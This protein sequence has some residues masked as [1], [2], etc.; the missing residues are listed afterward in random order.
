VELLS[1]EHVG[2]VVAT[3][4]AAAVAVPAARRWP[5]AVSRGLAVVIGVTY[6][7]EHAHFIARGTWSL[8]FNLP[9]H[10]TDVVTI[11]SVLALWTARPLLVELTWFWALTASLQAVL[12]PD[13]GA[14]FPELVY[15]TFFITHSGAVVAAVV[16]VIG[17]GIHPRPGAVGR[18]FVATL[19]VAA[20]AG[21][22]NLLTGGNYMWLREKPD[23][24]SLL[25]VMGP[26]PWY[27]L[28][29]AVVALVL[30]TLLAA[31][32]RRR[33][34][35][36]MMPPERVEKLRAW[37]DAA[38]TPD[39]DPG[40]IARYDYLGLALDIPE[41]V[42]PIF[43]VSHVFGECVR[44]E[45]RAGDRVLDMGTG[46]GVN[47]ILAASKAREVVAVDVN[48]D[49]IRAARENAALNGVE[50]KVVES[51]VFEH[52][53][54]A[55]DLILFDPPF[56]W[57]APRDMAERATADEDYR[58][59]RTFFEQVDAY[60]ARDGRILIFFGTSGDVDYL[61]HLIDR[62]G[63]AREE[64]RTLSGEKDG[65]PVTYWTFRLTRA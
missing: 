29:A 16:L 45:V 11:V 12:T 24:A 60:L 62:A 31:P 48:P 63:F 8:D 6:L 3:A 2:A 25:D 32:F 36:P 17:R 20:A 59:L 37:Q 64:L 1:D 46:S 40:R 50:I 34:H 42:Q 22:A 55:F 15:W 7:V 10:L 28:S 65:E 19:I 57:F 9:L 39:R 35:E 52:V 49:A 47:A 43:P 44:D 56:R 26:W 21:T 58:A 27:I 5:V 13:L 14:D 38:Y 61:L 4:V 53:E 41:T 18:V 33:R 51:D 54:G 23:T 30:F